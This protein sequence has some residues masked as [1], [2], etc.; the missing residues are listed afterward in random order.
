M[1]PSNEY[2]GLISYRIDLFDLLTVQGTLKDLLQHHSLKASILFFCSQ[3]SLQSE[4]SHPYV[5]T[6]KTIALTIWIIW[7]SNVSTF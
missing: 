5:T 2:S 4:T 7:Q 6:G 1:S 3:P